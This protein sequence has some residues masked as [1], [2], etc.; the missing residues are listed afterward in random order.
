MEVHVSTV[1]VEGSDAVNPREFFKTFRV[2]STNSVG[3]SLGAGYPNSTSNSTTIK[4]I[5]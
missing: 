2:L 1:P 3:G 5:G 4:S